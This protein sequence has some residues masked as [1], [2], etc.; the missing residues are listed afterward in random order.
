MR[1]G[2]FWGGGEEKIKKISSFSFLFRKRIF[3]LSE[4]TLS[5]SKEIQERSLG[6]ADLMT[7]YS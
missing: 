5:M 4:S 1:E 2:G 7:K 3:F 6:L